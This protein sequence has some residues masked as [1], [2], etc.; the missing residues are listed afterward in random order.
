MEFEM[1]ELN[2]R[3]FFLRLV[4]MALCLILLIVEEWQWDTQA[5]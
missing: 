5:N 3:S 4:A 1:F 2:A